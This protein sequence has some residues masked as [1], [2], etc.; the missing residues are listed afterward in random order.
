MLIQPNF[1]CSNSPNNLNVTERW[2]FYWYFY[3]SF[4]TYFTSISSVSIID[5]EQV[6]VSWDRIYR[7]WEN[8]LVARRWKTIT[9][10]HNLERN[11]LYL[12]KEWT[13]FAKNER[14]NLER[15]YLYLCKEWTPL[16]RKLLVFPFSFFFCKLVRFS[17]Y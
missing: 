10:K 6:N 5:V 7:I 17:N 1:D 8:K 4:W 11:Y 3:C 15:N 13:T 2:N 12:C 9:L 16:Q 14:N